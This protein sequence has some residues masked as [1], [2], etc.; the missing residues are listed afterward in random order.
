MLRSRRGVT[1]AAYFGTQA[2]KWQTRP[3]KRTLRVV[4]SPSKANCFF[5]LPT[6]GRILAR[7]VPKLSGVR[8]DRG[9]PDRRAR[10]ARTQPEGH[11][12]LPAAGR[13]GGRDR[14]LG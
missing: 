7:G 13:D 10:G 8:R 5:G 2:R 9:Q 14:A 1:G 3:Q 12:G 11:N 4:E 6:G